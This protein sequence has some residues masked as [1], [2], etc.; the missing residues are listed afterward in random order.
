[1]GLNGRTANPPADIIESFDIGTTTNFSASDPI[2]QGLGADSAFLLTELGIVHIDGMDDLNKGYVARN[3]FVE[4][5][6]GH[7]CLGF[8]QKMSA[9]LA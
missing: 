7:L 5:S 1:M 3:G 9:A 2:T 6:G 4:G 8:A